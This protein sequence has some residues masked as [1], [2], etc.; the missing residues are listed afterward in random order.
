MTEKVLFCAVA[1]MLVLEIILTIFLVVIKR[2]IGPPGPIGEK[3]DRGFPGKDGK[4]GELRIARIP[5]EG[6]L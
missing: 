4:N 1:G 3:G 5:D 2:R 6:K